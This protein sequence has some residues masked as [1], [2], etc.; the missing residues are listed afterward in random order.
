MRTSMSASCVAAWLFS[1]GHT[2]LRGGPGLLLLL[3]LFVH[4][5]VIIVVA[6]LLA[7]PRSRHI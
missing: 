5:Q 2:A 3:L 4:V 7:G 6:A 1:Q